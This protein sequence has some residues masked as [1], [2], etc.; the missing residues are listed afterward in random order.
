M[1]TKTHKQN[2]NQRVVNI[3]PQIRLATHYTEM[4]TQWISNKYHDHMKKLIPLHPPKDTQTKGKT[5]W[6]QN[7]SYTSQDYR[8]PVLISYIC[9]KYITDGEKMAKFTSPF[10]PHEIKKGYGRWNSNWCSRMKCELVN[11]KIIST[12][13]LNIHYL[14]FV[15]DRN[16]YEW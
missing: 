2:N 6:V 8:K 15:M 13:M 1:L 4:N 9:I 10:I 12:F 11:G 5:G 7:H 3:Y 14:N 16:E